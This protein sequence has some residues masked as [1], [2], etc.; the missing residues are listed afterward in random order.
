M[1]KL[2]RNGWFVVFVQ[3]GEIWCCGCWI[4]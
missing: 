4:V 3:I 1:L 2:Y